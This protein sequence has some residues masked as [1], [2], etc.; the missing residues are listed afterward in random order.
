MSGRWVGDDWAPLGCYL[1][2]YTRALTRYCSSTQPLRVQLFGG[3][4]ARRLFDQLV[5][6]LSGVDSLSETANANANVTEM[7]DGALVFESG[8]VHL[9]WTSWALGTGATSSS[10][11]A[12]ASALDNAEE[13]VVLGDSCNVTQRPVQEYESQLQRLASIVGGSAKVPPRLYWVAGSTGLEA[14]ACGP[15]PDG[16]VDW[17]RQ[18]VFASMSTEILSSKFHVIDA[19]RLAAAQTVVGRANSGRITRVVANLLL[20]VACNQHVV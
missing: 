20:N 15:C 19:L 11:V 13:V 10:S 9:R 12:L 7:S 5:G 6:I 18:H 14:T 4:G 8:R 16:A 17:H 2:P 3:C 1:L